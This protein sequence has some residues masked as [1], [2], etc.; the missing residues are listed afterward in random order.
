MYSTS[1]LICA[2]ISIV[3]QKITLC[4]HVDTKYPIVY[5]LPANYH[6][7]SSSHFGYSIRIFRNQLLI[8]APRA[9]SKL[10]GNVVK[11]GALFSCDIVTTLCQEVELPLERSKNTGQYPVTHHYREGM[12][13]GGTVRTSSDSNLNPSQA[14]ICAHCWYNEV[15]WTRKGDTD[16]HPVGRCWML[17]SVTNRTDNLIG[18]VNRDNWV[19][20]GSYY[21]QL[22]MQGMDAQFSTS[23]G[24][25][26]K[27]GQNLVVGAPGFYNFR[28]TTAAFR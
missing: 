17:D 21:H 7:G 1:L 15:N 19:S 8:G 4:L 11:T 13:L 14:A 23:A 5:E 6:H 3:Y 25:D 2:F 9:S 28:G 18:F 24:N 27:S 12:F 10:T 16:R 26:G 22:A 20:Q